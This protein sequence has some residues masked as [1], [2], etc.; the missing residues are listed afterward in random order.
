M[1]Q[2]T[3]EAPTEWLDC[4]DARS[5]QAMTIIVRSSIDPKMVVGAAREI[6]HQLDS[7][8]P[9][10][11]I[12]AMTEQMDRSLWTRRAYSWLFGAF[13][14]VAILLAR[15]GVYGTISYIVTQR[16][17]E[18]GI[19]MA[20]GARPAQ[21]LGQV[22]LGGMALIWIGVTAGLVS[23]LLATGLLGRCFSA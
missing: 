22:L 7:D 18:I 21:V 1:C 9:I 20:L 15:A 23:T 17:Q 5:L 14:M 13:A 3:A 4:N 6:V 11:A 10:Y 2:V 16:T 8:V 19:R 12:Q